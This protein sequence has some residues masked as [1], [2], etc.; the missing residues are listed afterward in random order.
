MIVWPQA[1]LGSISHYACLHAIYNLAMGKDNSKVL[2]IMHAA[3]HILLSNKLVALVSTYIY[4]FFL[5]IHSTLFSLKL[6]YP[7]NQVC[8]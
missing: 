1:F 3:M 4:I 6:Q 7:C 8:E 5:L 2:T